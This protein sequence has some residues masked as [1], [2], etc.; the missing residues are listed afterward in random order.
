MTSRM[1]CRGS[2]VK[3]ISR[4]THSHIFLLLLDNELMADGYLTPGPEYD[5]DIFV[6]APEKMTY[7]EQANKRAHC[8]RLAWYE[9]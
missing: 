5:Y 6:E 2:V 8:R 7:T 3:T 9:F 1:R 4:K